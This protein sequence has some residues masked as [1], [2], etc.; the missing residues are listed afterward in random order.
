MLRQRWFHGDIQATKAMDKLTGQEPSTFLVRFSSQPGCFT[1]SSVDPAGRVVHQRVTFEPDH[2]YV[3]WNNRYATLKILLRKEK[4]KFGFRIP[5]PDSQYLHLFQAVSESGGCYVAPTYMAAPMMHDSARGGDVFSS[6]DSPRKTRQ[7]DEKKSKQTSAP[8]Y[9]AE[10][11]QPPKINVSTLHSNDGGGG[12]RPK[13]RRTSSRSSGRSSSGRSSHHHK[14]K[15]SSSSKKK[16]K[17]SSSSAA[18]S[19][20]SSKSKSSKAKTSSSRQQ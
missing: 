1:I 10:S 16:K 19:S 3:F 9:I 18:H 17:S 6:F 7:A 13:S 4:R 12:D 20:R 8:V 15:S 2:G 14:K 11:D 5:C